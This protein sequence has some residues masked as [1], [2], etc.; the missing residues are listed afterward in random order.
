MLAIYFAR[1][2]NPLNFATRDLI[3]SCYASN[4]SNSCLQGENHRAAELIAADRL[5]DG[6]PQTSQF[7]VE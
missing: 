3:Y 6:I 4:S 1:C 5:N 7:A 2:V